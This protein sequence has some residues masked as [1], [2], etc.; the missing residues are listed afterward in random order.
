M[1]ALK[2][3]LF[4]LAINVTLVNIHVGNS[5]GIIL[6]LYSFAVKR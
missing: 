3:L 6:I 2:F 1:K 5:N 4:A